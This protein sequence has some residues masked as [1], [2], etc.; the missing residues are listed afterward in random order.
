MEGLM[1]EHVLAAPIATAFRKHRK[2]MSSTISLIPHVYLFRE[3][4]PQGNAA[5]IWG[6]T[7]PLKQSSLEIPSQS[8]SDMCF[9]LS[10]NPFEMI[11]NTE[12]QRGLC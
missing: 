3:L 8:R 7:F 9:L 4:K 2:G 1:Q 10:L 6:K 5:H 11:V 12:H